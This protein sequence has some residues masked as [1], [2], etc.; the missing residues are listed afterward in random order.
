MEFTPEFIRAA[1]VMRQREVPV[2]EIASS[3]ETVLS[4]KQAASGDR[5]AD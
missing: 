2:T 4:Q 1:R 5:F 3:R